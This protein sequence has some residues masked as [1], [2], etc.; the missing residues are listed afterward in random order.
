MTSRAQQVKDFDGDRLN[1]LRRLR[2]MSKGEVARELGVS[3]TAVAQYERGQS[4]PSAS[5]M[6][7]AC[8]M[9]GVPKDFFGRGGLDTRLSAS[10]AHFRSLR[11]TSVTKREQ[12]LAYGEL[13]L[14]L[15]GLLEQWVE[16]PEVKVPELPVGDSDLSLERIERITQE[17]R[18]EMGVAKGPV[19]NVVRLLEGHGVLV[20]RLPQNTVDRKVDA[21]STREGTRPLVMLSPDKNDKARSRFDAA[22]EL[23]HLVL[24]PDIEPGS[25]LAETQANLFASE[26]LMPRGE[27]ES[28]LPTRIDWASFHELKSKWGVSLRALV[29]RARTLDRLTDATYRRAN[30]QLSQ[31]GL[32]EPADLGR[33]E[34]PNLIG[35]AMRVLEASGVDPHEQIFPA[36]R[37]APEVIEQVIHGATDVR[38]RLKIAP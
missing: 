37:L 19:P 25:K 29:Y 8:L 1:L 16:F 15:T 17:I 9:F 33:P 22:H 11:S 3:A 31:W 35:E 26:F 13:A 36:A 4:R 30:Q 38:P 6:A 5:V 20:L 14:Q 23:G 24:H 34:A 12:A 28:V 32:P 2:A 21:F 10:E 7:K 18:A 27:L